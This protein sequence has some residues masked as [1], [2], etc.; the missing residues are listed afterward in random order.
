MSGPAG[1]DV[2]KGGKAHESGS[3]GCLAKAGQGGL[4]SAG[5]CP[6]RRPN[7]KRGVVGCS[8]ECPTVSAAGR[9]HSRGKWANGTA[10][11]LNRYG[12]YFGGENSERGANSG[13]GPRVRGDTTPASGDAE[14]SEGP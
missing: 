2:L 13:R 3:L 14:C 4:G 12:R 1:P 8:F 11:A 6:R 10:G 9:P 7:S 5:Q